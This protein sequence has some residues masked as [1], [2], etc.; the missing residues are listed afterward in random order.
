MGRYREAAV[1]LRSALDR[2]EALVASDPGNRDYRKAFGEGLA[3]L[4]EAYE[5]DGRLED[6]LAQRERQIAFLDRLIRVPRSDADYRRSVMVALRSA[7]RLFA[8][9]GDVKQGLKYLTRSVAL[10]DELMRTE[11]D[12]ASWAGMAAASYADLGQLQLESGQ[13]DE[14][15]TSARVACDITNRL[16]SRDSSVED[17]RLDRKSG[18][19]TLRFRLALAL[20]AT[21]EAQVIAKEMERL[22]KSEAAKGMTANKRELLLLATTLRGIAE[23]KLGDRVAARAAFAAA[24]TYWPKGMAQTPSITARLA[25]IYLGLGQGAEADREQ[26]KLDA[27]GYRH[28]TYLR[29]RQMIR[30]MKGESE[31]A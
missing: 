16:I 8:M 2:R 3:W 5:K 6:A 31:N 29:E 10:G 23:A 25:L 4:S 26:R 14:A 21:D 15:G 24:I 1:A 20:G 18:C 17:W 30:K 9:R 19:L 12:N 27:I 28:P 7:G 11:P 22:T 13:I